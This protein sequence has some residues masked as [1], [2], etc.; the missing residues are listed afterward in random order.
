MFR[1]P[2]TAFINF[3]FFLGICSTLDTSES[4]LIIPLILSNPISGWVICLPL[5]WT[6]SLTLLPSSKNFRAR[7][8]RICRSLGPILGRNRISLVPVVL[9]FF[10]DALCCR[11]LT[12]LYFLKSKIRTTGGLAS[13]E[14]STKSNPKPLAFWMASVKGKTPICLPSWSI[15]RTSG[16]LIWKFSLGLRFFMFL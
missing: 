14:T 15:T 8:V 7:F 6:V 10:L 1:G 2:N 16:L 11:F 9:V 5:N 13:A 3:P 12:K 4:V